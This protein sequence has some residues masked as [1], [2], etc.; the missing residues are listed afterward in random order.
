MGSL[1]GYHLLLGGCTEGVYRRKTEPN[2]VYRLGTV[3]AICL[4]EVLFCVLVCK[5]QMCVCVFMC[6]GGGVYI[7]GT[8]YGLHD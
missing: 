1:H 6:R 4:L 8:I 7:E 3:C 2:T 5:G